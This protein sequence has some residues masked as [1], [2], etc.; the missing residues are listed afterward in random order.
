VQ[1]TY[2]SEAN[3]GQVNE[4][5]VVAGADWALVLDGATKRADVDSG[6]IHG[7]GWARP[8]LGRAARRPPGGRARRAAARPG[9][10]APKMIIPLA[11]RSTLGPTRTAPC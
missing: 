8:D 10:P 1:I 9:S 5:Y 2:A 7:A 3:T 6:C 4:D 11:I